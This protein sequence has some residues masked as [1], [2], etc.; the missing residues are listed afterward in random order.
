MTDLDRADTGRPHG[1]RT[2]KPASDPAARARHTGDPLADAVVAAMRAAAPER[3][4][5]LRTELDRGIR[6]GLASLD[7]PAPESAA[8]LRSAESLPPDTDPALLDTGALPLFTSPPAVHTLS[9]SAGAL[10][11][12]YGSPS[13]AVLLGTTG[14]LVDGAARRITET[15]RW[16]LCATLPGGL[17]PGAPGYVA[18]LQVRM[19]HAHMRALARSR[20]HDEARHGV[21]INQIDLARTWLDFTLVSLRA[22]AAI[23]FDLTDDEITQVYAYWRV[24]AHQLGIDPELV[25]GVTDHTS[26]ARLDALVSRATGP[27]GPESRV[28]AGAL[29]GAVAALLHGSLRLPEPVGRRLLQVLARRFHGPVVADA[30]GMRRCVPLDLLVGVAAWIVRARRA[31]MR[32]TP[33]AVAARHERYVAVTRAIVDGDATGPAL[34]QNFRPS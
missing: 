31:R 3:A 24:L 6:H 13:I 26:A 21:P 7:D 14:R 18:T 27:P 22:E 32:C 30:L 33:G 11:R 17:R 4:R 20:G 19:L 23:G 10:L 29:V 15:G 28:L 5:E 16:V 9:L 8:L 34:F 2:G 12:T 25:G 1:I